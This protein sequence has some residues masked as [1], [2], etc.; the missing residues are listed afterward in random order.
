MKKQQ[1]ESAF[2]SV[3]DERIELIVSSSMNGTERVGR[4]PTEV[5]VS[6]SLPYGLATLDSGAVSDR[7]V[8]LS[9]DVPPPR[10]APRGRSG[11]IV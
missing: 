1:A 10:Q 11:G 8:L 9:L 7:L 4:P 2:G 6:L 3:H 5:C